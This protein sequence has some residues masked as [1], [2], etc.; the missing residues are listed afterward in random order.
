[1]SGQ[2]GSKRRCT[3]GSGK[4]AKDCCFKPKPIMEGFTFEYA[5]PV[6]AEEI[7]FDSDGSIKIITTEEATPIGARQG[8][9]YTR[10]KG[11]KVLIESPVDLENVKLGRGWYDQTS[12]YNTIFV[13]DTNTREI[14]GTVVSLCCVALCSL[15]YV[16]GDEFFFKFAPAML[17]E[18]HECLFSQ[19]QF[20]WF[21]LH[22]MIVSSRRY[23][24]SRRYAIV[25]DCDLGNHIHYNNRTM[26]IYS[27]VMLASNVD[28]LYASSDVGSSPLNKLIRECDRIAREGL[29]SAAEAGIARSQARYVLDGPCSRFQLHPFRI[30]ELP[31][32]WLRLGTEIPL[33]RAPSAPL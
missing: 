22:S 23:D 21:I 27:D 15:D 3:C 26:P 6:T 7:V 13:L 24:Q 5:N 4:I 14:E 20:S 25:T 19:E 10:Q 28:L 32:D 18:F 31:A 11:P 1:M 8:R 17:I 2:P 9:Y 29:R 33:R 30:A 16:G 12:K